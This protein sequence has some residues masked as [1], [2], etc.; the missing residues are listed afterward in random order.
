MEADPVGVSWTRS[1]PVLILAEG[2]EETAEFRGPTGGPTMCED[3]R[4]R[5]KKRRKR[6]EIVKVERR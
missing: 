1:S 4:K 5:E 3:T 6:R 2:D